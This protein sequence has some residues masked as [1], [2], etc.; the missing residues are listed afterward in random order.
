MKYSSVLLFNILQN[1]FIVA[2]TML[3]VIGCS[4]EDD[5]EMIFADKQ[6]KITGATINGVSLNNEVKELYAN[7][8][9]IKFTQS[10]FTAELA[11][12]SHLS[13]TWHADGKH[14]TINLNIANNNLTDKTLLSRN[15]YTII[16]SATHYSGDANV[17][18]IHKDADNYIILNSSIK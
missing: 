16:K 12:G 11:E 14:K 7:P 10:T 5:V 1:T 6:W 2:F 13:G 17:T 15:I 18:K 3:S 4:E 8:Y 9:Y